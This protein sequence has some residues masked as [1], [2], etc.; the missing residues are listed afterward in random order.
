MV[1]LTVSSMEY[2]GGLM[3][4]FSSLRKNAHD[5]SRSLFLPSCSSS[6]KCHVTKPTGLMPSQL[7]L[8]SS[9]S[10]KCHVSKPTALMP[11]QL[12]KISLGHFSFVGHTENMI[13]GRVP[14]QQQLIRDR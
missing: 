3:T 10:N 2:S 7:L 14:Q 1:G 13:I 9:L 12:T 6:N 8:S 11:I 5:S 4:L